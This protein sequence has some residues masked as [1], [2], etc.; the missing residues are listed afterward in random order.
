MC[1]LP[2]EFLWFPWA[3][4]QNLVFLLLL[5]ILNHSHLLSLSMARALSRHCRLL[6][7]LIV[8]HGSLSTTKRYGSLSTALRWKTTSSA[9]WLR[10]PLPRWLK[11]LGRASSSSSLSPSEMASFSGGMKTIK[12]AEPEPLSSWARISLVLSLRVLKNQKSLYQMNI[13]LSKW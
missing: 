10:V 7:Q 5:L 6:L 8:Q 4:W 11:S 3:C 2:A 12:T 9:C 1:Y 13:S